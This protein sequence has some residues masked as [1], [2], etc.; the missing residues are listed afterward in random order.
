[1]KYILYTG[2][3]QISI[4]KN[5][6]ITLVIFSSGSNNPTVDTTININK[7]NSQAKI[8]G[9]VIGKNKDNIKINTKQ[10]HLKGDTVSDL[11]IKGVFF[12]E[13][14]FSY[15]GLIRIEKDAQKS[16]A[17]QRN[18]N[19]ILSPNAHVDTKPELEI[20]ANDVR[21]T[22]GATIGRINEEQIF[23]LESRGLAKNAARQLVIQGFLGEIVDK[24]EDKEIR[25]IIEKKIDYCLTAKD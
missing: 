16:N 10:L 12:E 24:I 19:L 20:E 17:Y 4:D 18:E 8:L 25:E 11:L 14:R 23:Y 13:S 21:C 3:K 6:E 22:H 15:D 2:Q 1:M 5:N 7:P 9:I